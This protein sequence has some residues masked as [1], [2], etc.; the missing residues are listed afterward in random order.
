MA[1]SKLD[2]GRWLADIE[3]IKG[4]RFRRKFKTKGEALRFETGVRLK[5]AENPSWSAKPKDRRKLSE[6]VELWFDLHGQTLANGLRC[7]AILRLM[8]KDLG[9]PVAVALEPSKVAKVRSKQ[10]SRGMSAKYANNRLGYLKSM[11]NELRQL[12]VI[13]YEN[14]IGRLRPLK[15]QERPLSFLTEFQVSELLAALDDRHTS[16]HPRMV[17]RICLATGARWGEAQALTPDRLKGRQVVF[18]NTKSRRVRSVPISDELGEA[19]RLHWQTYG[20]FTNCLGVFRKVLLA[21][22][23]K[24][25][26]GQ[27]SHV[28]RH[29]FASHFI[30]NGGHIVTLQNIL[31]HASL[32]M[33]MRYAHLSKDHLSEAVRLNPLGRI[34]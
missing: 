1:V 22:S 25:P 20:P 23:I 3:P 32:A 29:T 5:C 13:D 30:M 21:T 26:R 6:L 11:Y 33:T 14:P 28:L 18:A 15:L 4:K 12:G 27:A 10:V 19:I 17:A 24:L 7:V 9:D 8:V 16:P 31:G 34:S 2:D